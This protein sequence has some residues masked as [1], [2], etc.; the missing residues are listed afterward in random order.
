MAAD[1][2]ASLFEPLATGRPLGTGLAIVHE[3]TEA[4]GDGWIS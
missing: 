2:R 1:L 3:L 4:P